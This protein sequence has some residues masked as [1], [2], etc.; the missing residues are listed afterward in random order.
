[1]LNDFKDQ[2]VIN[3]TMYDYNLIKCLGSGFK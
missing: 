1:M 2:G 3:L